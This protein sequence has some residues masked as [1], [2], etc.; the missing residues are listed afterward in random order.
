MA[1]YPPGSLAT[2]LPVAASAERDARDVI[3]GNEVLR[4]LLA[5]DRTS[6]PTTDAAARD[7]MRVYLGVPKQEEPAPL[8]YIMM[9]G[10]EPQYKAAGGVQHANRGQ[11]SLV[12]LRHTLEIV[13]LSRLYEEA[14]DI[15]ALILQGLEQN[16][17]PHVRRWQVEGYQMEA[18]RIDDSKMLAGY[19]VTIVMLCDMRAAEGV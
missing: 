8:V 14:A 9:S 12:A 13:V 7:G 19:Q 16:E 17:T 6:P 10:R 5:R 3:C 4:T 11:A 1:D 15:A 2:R 18:V